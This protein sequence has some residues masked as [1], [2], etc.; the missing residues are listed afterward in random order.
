MSALF[1]VRQLQYSG[2]FP[3]HTED[4]PMRAPPG[5]PA[6]IRTDSSNPFAHH[7]MAV[8]VPAIIDTLVEQNVEDEPPIIQR[9]LALAAALRE[10]QPIIGPEPARP[11]VDGWRTALAERPGARWLETDWFF[12]E[13]YAYRQLCDRVGFWETERDPFRQIKLAE[14]ASAAHGSA[15]NAAARIDGPAR[16]RLALLL[17]ASVFGNRMDLSFAA[18]RERGIQAT[19]DDLLID[20]RAAA[21]EILMASRG[22]VHL[23]V[24]NAG[25]ELSVDLVLVSRLLELGQEEVVLHVK[26]HPCFVS[27]AIASDVRWFLEGDDA[28]CRACWQGASSEALDCRSTLRQ[29]LADG[30]LRLAPHPFWNSAGSLW[31]MPEELEREMRDARLVILK[32]DAH[33]RRAVGDA[34]WPADTPTATVLS[35]F[36]APLLTLRTNKSDPIVG[37]APGQAAALES[38]DPRWRV[39][40]Q[41]G[42]AALGGQRR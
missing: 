12:A 42:I 22:A 32:G 25:T 34:L 13:N 38:L 10:N 1:S 31:D 17:A 2:A 4:S 5:L 29:A 18:S 14:Y 39:N 30:R 6:R 16:G 28:T 27:D 19:A 40:G 24:D 26:L 33:Y 15:L 9:L 35:Y 20:D 7:T 3:A 36:P 8:R 23:V 11:A 37:L 21:V 41:R